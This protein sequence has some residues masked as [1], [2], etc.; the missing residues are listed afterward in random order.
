MAHGSALTVESN[1]L[2]AASP[3][4][5]GKFGGC[6][7]AQSGATMLLRDSLVH[8]CFESGVLV[9]GSHGTIERTEVRD[10]APR[11]SDGLA[12]DAVAF[13]SDA[14]RSDGTL[15]HAILERAARAGLLVHGADTLVEGCTFGCNPI[16]LN[17]ES[18]SAWPDDLHDG[19][20][21]ACGCEGAAVACTVAHAT[22]EPPEPLP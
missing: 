4:A 13:V 7:N 22:L 17:S 12:G 18:S 9:L 21:N 3:V 8:G 10:V 14:R 2:R 16:H 19:G 5:N 15:R 1:V 20:G 11:A 6:A